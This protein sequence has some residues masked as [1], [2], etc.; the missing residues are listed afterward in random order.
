MGYSADV[1]CW[2]TLLGHPRGINLLDEVIFLWVSHLEVI[3]GID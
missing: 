2:V 1:L 3:R